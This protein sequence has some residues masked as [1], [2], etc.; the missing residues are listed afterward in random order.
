MKEIDAE[1]T[2]WWIF[3]KYLYFVCSRKTLGL[4]HPA[5][6]DTYGFWIFSRLFF[7]FSTKT[8]LLWK[9][10]WWPHTTKNIIITYVKYYL[11]YYFVFG[12]LLF[13]LGWGGGFRI[14]FGSFICFIKHFL[15]SKYNSEI[16]LCKMELIWKKSTP[17]LHFGELKNKNLLHV[18]YFCKR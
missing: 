15:Y 17:K 18:L 5:A 14:I 16:V 6:V 2:F 12:E 8:F 9:A 7:D 10:E 11:S 13:F 1:M 4:C 3:Q